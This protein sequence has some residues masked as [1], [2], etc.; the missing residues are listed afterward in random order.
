M[1]KSSQILLESL[2]LESVT[3]NQVKDAIEGKYKVRINYNSHGENLATG[4]RIIEVFAYGLTK[5]G[6]PVIRAW[7]P[8]GDT[9]SDIPD[10][11][12]FRLDRILEWNPTNQHFDKP[13]PKYNPNG[14][15][16]MSIMYTNAKFNDEIPDTPAPE[17]ISP[18][19][20]EEPV[21][22]TDS[23]I[24]YNK[25]YQNNRNPLTLK[26]LGIDY[27][28]KPK[29]NLHPSSN[30]ANRN[31]SAIKT[32][33]AFKQTDV[34]NNNEPE[35]NTGPKRK[36]KTSEPLTNNDGNDIFKTD[37]EREIEKRRQQLNNPT[38]VDPSVMRDYEKNR[39]KRNNIKY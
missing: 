4:W 22:K 12:F 20:K 36:E 1:L 6:N 37:T 29:A 30:D 10:W 21:H 26:D 11:K 13:E 7:Q 8:S 16:S 34:N 35:S 24:N 17:P 25:Q 9:V 31:L 14:D 2:L 28:F 32:N 23:E 27:D 38:Y 3:P 33:D 5:A 19:K 18:R 39:N 15:R